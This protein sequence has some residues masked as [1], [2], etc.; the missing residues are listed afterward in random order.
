MVFSVV[1]YRCEKWTIKKAEKRRV[2]AFKLWCCRRLLRVPWAAR[3][4]NQSILKEISPEYSLEGLMLKL[5]SQYFVHLMQRADH[6]KRPWCWERLKAWGTT[7][8]EMV[9]WHHRLDVH[10]FE[11]VPGV[12]DEQGP[13]CA[14]V[15]GVTKSRTQLSDWTELNTAWHIISLS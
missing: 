6:L 4:S 2:D 10:D 14:A 7:E 1:M 15:H 5:K 8:N 13:W 9:G 3:K 11:Q 12:G